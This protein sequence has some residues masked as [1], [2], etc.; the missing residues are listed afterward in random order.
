MIAVAEAFVSI[1]HQENEAA[2]IVFIGVTLAVLLIWNVYSLSRV[3]YNQR[4]YNYYTITDNIR[5]SSRLE[6]G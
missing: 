2:Q 3:F 5:K 6:L 4:D 1:V